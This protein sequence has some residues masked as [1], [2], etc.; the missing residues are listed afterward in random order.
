MQ[1]LSFFHVIIA[2]AF[3]VLFAAPSAQQQ[4]ML[5]RT[6]QPLRM[7]RPTGAALGWHYVHPKN[8][9]PIKQVME[10]GDSRY[11][12]NEA[13]MIKGQWGIITA[14]FGVVTMAQM[15]NARLGI[16][17]RMPRTTFTLQMHNDYEE[18]SVCVRPKDARGGKGMPNI[19]HYTFKL[20]T[21]VPLFELMPI[22]DGQR[23]MESEANS[24]LLPGRLHIP[25]DTV[26]VPQ[27]RVDEYHVF[28]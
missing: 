15:E 23:L 14:D 25:L 4:Q 2:S 7:L 17:R 26:V 24:I 10:Y 22:N 12:N 27:G 6:G 18:V 13:A 8:G 16:L 3:V 28:K 20:T 9:K 5:R 1:P 11:I 19:H 21:G